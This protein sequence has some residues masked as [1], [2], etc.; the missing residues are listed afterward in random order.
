MLGIHPRLTQSQVAP[1][2]NE[3]TLERLHEHTT[4]RRDLFVPSNTAVKA[5]LGGSWACHQKTTDSTEPPWGERRHGRL[6]AFQLHSFRFAKPMA[7]LEQGGDALLDWIHDWIGRH[8]PGSDIAW[9]PYCVSNR[10]L[11]WAL[12]ESRFGWSDEVM[13]RSYA[14]QV[15][16]LKRSLEWDIRANHLMKNACALT[17]AGNLLGGETTRA[18]RELLESQITEQVLKDGGHYECCPMYHALVLE[19][20][21]LAHASF[22]DKPVYL[23]DAIRRMTGWLQQIIHPDGDIPLFGDSVLAEAPRAEELISLA[24][25]TLNETASSLS[26][27]PLEDSGYR[28][29]SRDGLHV[30]VKTATA[31]PAFQP[32]HS[33]ADATSYELS[34]DGL[35]FVVDTGTHGYAESPWRDYCRRARAH[36][37]ATIDDIDPIDVWSVFRVGRRCKTWS[38]ELPNSDSEWNLEAG[39][40]AF[41]GEYIRRFQLKERTLTV[42]DRVRLD[43]PRRLVSRL[44]LHP[45]VQVAQDG[46]RFMLSREGVEVSLEAT[47]GTLTYL[48]P[49]A[50]PPEGWYFPEFGKA[51]PAHRFDIVSE[52]AKDLEVEYSLFWLLPAHVVM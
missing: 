13:L 24:R 28:S 6:W 11:N 44:H 22:R 12:A 39:H 19:D 3:D 21:L 14:A 1:A 2:F 50:D 40:D 36:N 51:L 26:A 23:T 32:G 9:D 47:H 41:P 46:G 5:I 18:A 35:R 20:L 31:T 15:E 16:W 7:E 4:L 8:P 37:V 34:V 17:V 43:R 30:L 33:H 48:P 25:R 10:L 45:E 49:D 42:T 27:I 52:D 29:A 38:K